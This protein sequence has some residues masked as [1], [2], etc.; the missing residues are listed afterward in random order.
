MISAKDFG[1]VGDGVTDD[2]K[3][4]QAWASQTSQRHLGSGTYLI[5]ETIVFA[6]GG[7]VFRYEGTLKLSDGFSGR[8]VWVCNG[9]PHKPT[10]IQGFTVDMNKQKVYLASDKECKW[11]SIHY[12]II[13]NTYSDDVRTVF[14]FETDFYQ[15][16]AI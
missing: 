7:A 10:F 4:I 3:A 5:S 2:T 12:N 6:A 8:S 15:E 11:T 14:D 9:M 1:A 16:V 13:K